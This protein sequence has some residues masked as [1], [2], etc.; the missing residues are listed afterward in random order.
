[1]LKEKGFPY[2][3]VTHTIAP[4]PG[5]PKLVHLTFNMSE[6][7][8]GQD[9]PGRLRRQQGDQRRQLR[10]QMKHNKTEGHVFASSRRR[11]RIMPTSSR[12]TPS[13]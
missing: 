2:A 9:P 5:G 6:G 7:P 8:E 12:K 11:A 13:G 3:D 1:M 4:M 10:K